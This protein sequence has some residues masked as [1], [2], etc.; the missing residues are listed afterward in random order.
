MFRKNEMR[1][2][3]PKMLFEKICPACRNKFRTEGKG[4]VY[5][6]EFSCKLE[7]KKNPYKAGSFKAEVFKRDGF[8]CQ[9]C[10]RKA[11]EIALILAKD[12]GTKIK[13]MTDIK[14]GCISCLGR[15]ICEKPNS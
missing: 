11:E 14:T 2:I 4:K 15:K 12:K 1:E 9:Y 13:E 6:E 5:C 10:G 3:D 8:T 7:R